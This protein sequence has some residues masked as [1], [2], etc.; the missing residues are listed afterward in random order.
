MKFFDKQKD[1]FAARLARS[2]RNEFAPEMDQIRKEADELKKET[3]ERMNRAEKKLN[4]T[5]DDVLKEAHGAKLGIVTSA[6]CAA[7]AAGASIA[8]CVA[9][10]SGS[11]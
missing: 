3:Q 8:A 4:D 7:I 2:F 6:I 5:A 9:V 11:K 10:K 1:D